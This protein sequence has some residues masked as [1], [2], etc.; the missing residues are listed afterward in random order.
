MPGCLRK[1]TKSVGL[2]VLHEFLFEERY[3]GHFSTNYNGPHMQ[4]L[5]RL[6]Q[7]ESVS[8]RHFKVVNTP[9]EK[10]D[11]LVVPLT[12]TLTFKLIFQ[13]L[14]NKWLEIA[15]CNKIISHRTT[16]RF[17]T[18]NKH[19]LSMFVIFE[20]ALEKGFGYLQHVSLFGVIC[21]CM[22]V[23]GCVLCIFSFSKL[24]MCNQMFS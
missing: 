20:S 13:H 17:V 1:T 18:H 3:N 15:D 22:P 19:V 7:T 12:K 9:S 14:L 24:C 23:C 6:L 5:E 8:R 11:S 10:W 21:F 16:T 4:N 2:I